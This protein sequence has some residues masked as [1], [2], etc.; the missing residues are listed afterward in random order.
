VGGADADATAGHRLDL[1]LESRHAK[2][3]LLLH[4][5]TNLGQAIIAQYFLEQL[6]VDNAAFRHIDAKT[7][8]FDVRCGKGASNPAWPRFRVA[9]TADVLVDPV[10]TATA[11]DLVERCALPDVRNIVY[12]LPA[13]RR[14]CFPAPTSNDVHSLEPLA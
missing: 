11:L 12:C 13:A 5:R 2:R 1:A 10:Y 8:I 6:S 9:R 4:V 7:Q 3:A 14:P